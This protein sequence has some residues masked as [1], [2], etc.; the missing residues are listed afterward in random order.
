MANGFDYYCYT[1][2]LWNL[3]IIFLLCPVS[4]FGSSSMTTEFKLFS[5]SYS[6]VEVII[7][8]LKPMGDYSIET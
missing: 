8:K 1:C 2:D 7:C 3:I 4:D 5:S 6:S